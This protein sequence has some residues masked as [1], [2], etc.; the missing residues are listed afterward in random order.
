M[1]VKNSDKPILILGAYG[2]GNVGDDIFT[3][4]AASMLKNRR[5]YVNSA[6][7]S[8]LPNEVKGR[9]KTISTTNSSDYKRKIKL[10]FS[11]KTVIYW[12]GDLWVELYGAPMP[13]QLLYK[14]LLVN[15]LL[16]LFGKKVYYVGCGIGP[17]AGYSLM[18]AKM[19][20]RLSDGLILREARSAKLIGV[21][22][23]VMPDLAVNIPYLVDAPHPI[24]SERFTIVISTLWS[25]PS[26]DKNFQNMIEGIAE[27]VNKLPYK[28]V[29][30]VLLPM[31]INSGEKGYDDLWACEELKKILDGDVSIFMQ[32]ELSK[33]VDLLRKAD[34]IIGGRLHANIIGLLNSTPCIG[35]SYRPKIKSFFTDNRLSEYC[36]ELSEVDQLTQ[37]IMYVHDNYS[38][39]TEAFYNAS[40]LNKKYRAEYQKIV[41]EMVG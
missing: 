21:K 12:G 17:L 40:A 23:T 26:P 33:V 41:T 32:R 22:S 39:A 8:L 13:R 20:A 14:M 4:T 5:V 30:V 18:L 7:D 27:A 38:V 36:L 19:S 15:C 10:F 35:L 3:V 31:H 25:I 11:I 6:D 28:H 24:F 34:L 9:L 37:K 16:K 29:R 1:S 2:R